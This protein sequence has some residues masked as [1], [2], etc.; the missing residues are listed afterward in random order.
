MSM[1]FRSVV[2]DDNRV[3]LTGVEKEALRKMVLA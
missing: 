3:E 1:S 2:L